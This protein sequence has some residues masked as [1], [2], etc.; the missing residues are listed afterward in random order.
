MKRWK[1][2]LIFTAL[3][4]SLAVTPAHALEYDI[5]A[6]DD[7]LFGRPTSDET[8]YEQAPVNVDRSKNT[9][10]VLVRLPATC[11]AA[12][13]TCLPTLSPVL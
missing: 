13:S 5:G 10:P 3:M 9:R 2:L 12:V 6:P 8:I 4:A 1:H 11:P 7:Y